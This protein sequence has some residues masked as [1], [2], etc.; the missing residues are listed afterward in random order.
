MRLSLYDKAR[1]AL[2][3]YLFLAQNLIEIEYVGDPY[4][5]PD[6]SPTILWETHGAVRK[7]LEVTFRQRLIA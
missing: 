7:C 5:L 4:I 3:S 6:L 2:F 1:R